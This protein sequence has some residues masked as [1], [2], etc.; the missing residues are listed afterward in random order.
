MRKF[1]LI[2]S[3]LLACTIASE[4]G[5]AQSACSVN[6]LF[7]G[8]GSGTSW[9]YP[10]A[11][12]GADTSRTNLIG[13]GLGYLDYNCGLI[14]VQGGVGLTDYFPYTYNYKSGAYGYN[15]AEIYGHGEGDVFLRDPQKY[16]LGV[17]LDYQLD[18]FT[19]TGYGTKLG[20]NTNQFSNWLEP[21]AFGEYYL[22]DAVTLG[23]VADYRSGSSADQVS[24]STMQS[25]G[26]SA[27]VNYYVTPNL[28]V[29]LRGSNNDVTS[30]FTGYAEYDTNF[31]GKLG[32]IYKVEDSPISLFTNVIYAANNYTYSALYSPTANSS[33]EGTVGF[34]LDIGPHANRSLVESDR[35]GVYLH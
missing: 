12:A 21:M 11:P 31:S 5:I 19:K 25:Y 26:F 24:S 16:A 15:M 33:I 20:V 10:N 7:E 18:N 13:N 1:L 23:A 32:A 6:G 34:R 28:R 35:N 8:Y 4:H 30:Q 17:G 3:S 22:N 9:N 27:Y 2:S 14:N 29:G